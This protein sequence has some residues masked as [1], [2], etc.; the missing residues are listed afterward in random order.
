M[1]PLGRHGIMRP[2]LVLFRPLLAGYYYARAI[3]SFARFSSQGG[4]ADGNQ[5]NC[6]L[7][8]GLVKR[9]R[10]TRELITS[11][12]KMAASGTGKEIRD[13]KQKNNNNNNDSED[14]LKEIWKA[15]GTRII[16]ALD[17]GRWCCGARGA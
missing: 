4:R 8:P 13:Q 10:R 5:S 9:R 6:W 1:K 2:C 12:I 11:K 16:Q 7:R 15:G 14:P 17:W 3:Y